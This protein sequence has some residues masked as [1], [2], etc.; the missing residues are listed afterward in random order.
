MCQRAIFQVRGGHKESHFGIPQVAPGLLHELPALPLST[1]YTGILEFARNKQNTD[2]P[3]RECG[4]QGLDHQA[5]PECS[6][7]WGPVALLGLQTLIPV[8]K[9][10]AYLSH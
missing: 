6:L 10:P 8:D 3:M 7:G 5:S 9:F 2:G 4:Q 1:A